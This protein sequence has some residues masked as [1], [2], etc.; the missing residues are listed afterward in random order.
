[1]V[2]Q[3][4]KA[5]A[6]NLDQTSQEKLPMMCKRTEGAQ[7]PVWWEAGKRPILKV[8]KNT[9]N[10]DVWENGSCSVRL[11]RR[12][13]GGIHKEWRMQE[14]SEKTGKGQFKKIF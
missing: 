5:W 6:S 11:N 7:K 8:Q 2:L 12:I 4:H 3:E 10:N 1:M 9:E 13:Q 14:A